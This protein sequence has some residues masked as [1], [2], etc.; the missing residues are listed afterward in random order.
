MSPKN[1]S[2]NKSKIKIKKPISSSTTISTLPDAL[3]STILSWIHDTA[4][5]SNFRLVNRRFCELASPFLFHFADFTG[6]R[7]LELFPRQFFKYVSEVKFDWRT[8][9]FRTAWVLE[10]LSDNLKNVHVPL[11]HKFVELQGLGQCRNMEVLHLEVGG[12]SSGFKAL[13]DDCFT[14]KPFRPKWENVRSLTI[15]F[16]PYRHNGEI[17]LYDDFAP[18]FP[19]L[20][21]L[22][23]VNVDQI[24]LSLIPKSIRALAIKFNNG[25]AKKDQRPNILVKLANDL[26]HLTKLCLRLDFHFLRVPETIFNNVTDLEMKVTLETVKEKEHFLILSTWLKYF[27]RLRMFALDIHATEDAIDELQIGDIDPE[28]VLSLSSLTLLTNYGP[29]IPE[30]LTNFPNLTV[31]DLN[32]SC[33]QLFD[34]DEPDDALGDF[35][36]ITKLSVSS[37]MFAEDGKEINWFRESLANSYRLPKK[38]CVYFSY[39]TQPHGSESGSVVKLWRVVSEL[40]ETFCVKDWYFRPA[41]LD[42]ISSK[43]KVLLLDYGDYPTQLITHEFRKA[44]K[45]L[46]QRGIQ[47]E[48]NLNSLLQTY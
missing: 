39:C 41:W 7:I 12:L 11:D 46:P 1:K 4:T 37:G 2:K 19:T 45:R 6:N 38:K 33:G 10:H 43:L 3:V 16:I 13:I 42:A 31:L 21:Q 9:P 35:S 15:E 26:P 47:V 27:P 22:E 40:V 24:N 34:D 29:R 17:A 25:L 28:W 30:I 32:Y 5:L 48:G 36:K 23:I 14:I 18:F 44:F 8:C 20:K